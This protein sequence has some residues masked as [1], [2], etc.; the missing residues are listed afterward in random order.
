LNEAG[1]R[2]VETAFLQLDACREQ[3]AV[4]D[5]MVSICEARAGAAEAEIGKLNDSV[6]TLQET[7]RLKDQIAARRET[8]HRA[9]LR[10]ARG[11]WRRRFV[12]ALQYVAVGV[13]IGVVV[14]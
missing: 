10:A 5:Q 4:K 14:R 12:R 9:E 3:S 2:Q 8:E 1:L 7:V 13:V 11:T 6:R